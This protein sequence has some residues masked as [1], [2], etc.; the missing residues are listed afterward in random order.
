[1]YFG[2]LFLPKSFKIKSCNLFDL[3]SIQYISGN[4]FPFG[5]EI[6]KQMKKKQRFY[7]KTSQNKLNVS[8]F[9][10]ILVLYCLQKVIFAFKLFKKIKIFLFDIEFM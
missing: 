7:A 8:L 2:I 1:M 6:F 3:D 4:F 5:N 9:R 10:I